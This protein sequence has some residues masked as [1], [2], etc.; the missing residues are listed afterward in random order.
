MNMDMTPPS[1]P[2]TGPIQW[3]RVF[4][5][6]DWPNIVLL[7]GILVALGVVA[8]STNPTTR[9]F[10]IYDA[11][12]SYRYTG[13][14]S[15][16]Y[17]VVLVV[18]LVSVLL[19]LAVFERMAL[20]A[21]HT[22]A[23]AAVAVSL[24]FLLEWVGCGLI[25]VLLTE[26]SKVMVGYYRPDWLDRCNPAIPSTLNISIGL[27]PTS[28]PVCQSEEATQGALKDGNKSFPSGHSSTA[29]S[30]GVYIAGYV[31]WSA[32][33]RFGRQYAAKPE[34]QKSFGRRFLAE[35]GGTLTF[36][37]VL[38]QLCWAW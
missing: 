21:L 17:W 9:A 20:K 31:L 36:L 13:G 27:P 37:W 2:R 23:T 34:E 30:L 19:S 12:I 18:A 6:Q 28:N 32:Y 4:T 11:T 16:P 15:I 7:A 22:D 25:T 29:F 3:K 35:M 33:F 8:T 38:F 14:S 10:S 1:T 24:H 5:S 26:I